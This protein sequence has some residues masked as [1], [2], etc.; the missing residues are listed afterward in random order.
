MD[1]ELAQV[2]DQA[3]GGPDVLPGQPVP[4]LQKQAVPRAPAA[5]ANQAKIPAKLM[6]GRGVH[7]LPGGNAIILPDLTGRGEAEPVSEARHVSVRL[8]VQAAA[9]ALVGV[10]GEDV[11]VKDGY[12]VGH[13]LVPGQG[14]G[15]NSGRRIA[16]SYGGIKRSRCASPTANAPKRQRPAGMTGGPLALMTGRSGVGWGEG[17]HTL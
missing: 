10:G 4:V 8:P 12:A 11:G 7:P 17:N 13:E 5:L 3:D 14:H 9:L 2:V 15:Q 16:Q 6:F 1:A